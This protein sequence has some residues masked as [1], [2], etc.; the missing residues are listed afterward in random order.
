MRRVKVG[1]IGCGKIFPAYVQNLVDIYSPLVEVQ[2]CA[3]LVI[4]A[5]RSRAEEFGIPKALT[6]DELLADPEIELAVNLTIPSA[7]YAV[8]KACLEAGKHVFAEK[9]LAVTREEGQL[10]VESARN[11]NLRLGGAADTFLGAGLQAC[12]R[13]LDEGQLGTPIAANAFFAMGVHAEF[14][15]KVGVGP[16]YDMGPYYL[17]ALV[18]LLGPATRV[19]GSAQIPFPEKSNPDP[20]TGVS[21]KPYRVET[22]T[23]VSGVVDFANGCVAPV[24]TTTEAFGYFPRLEVYGTEGMVVAN[25]PNN[26]SGT[27]T[28]HRKKGGATELLLTGYTGQGRGLGVAEMAYGI[29]TG[30]PHRASGDLMYHVLDLMHAFHA[31]SRDGVHVALESACEKPTPFDYETL[32]NAT[33]D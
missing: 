12:R 15:H 16:M 2:A 23:V 13:A 27:V 6:V 28:L 4:E 29:A 3:D 10:L 14:Y 8:T 24:T 33:A 20:Q 5:A 17:T 32:M 11:R 21:S 19:T 26:Y 18:A 25:D 31:A 30:Q 22:P 7:H 9:P 1:I